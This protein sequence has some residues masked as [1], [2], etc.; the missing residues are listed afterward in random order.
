MTRCKIAYAIEKDSLRL[1]C[2]DEVPNGKACNCICPACGEKL[3]ARN[4]GSKL[5]HHFSHMSGNEC[6]YALQTTIHLL[7][8]EV[9]SEIK[10]IMLPGYKFF[11]PQLV[12]L[13][14]VEI[15]QRNDC[16]Y[17][18]PD[19]VGITER[20]V[21]ILIEIFVTHKVDD[22]KRKKI[23]EN[24]LNCIEIRFPRDTEP[25]K[26]NIAHILRTGVGLEAP[27][28]NKLED[29]QA[30]M[31]AYG[32]SAKRPF[33][34]SGYI[35]KHNE[36][37]DGPLGDRWWI[38][39]PCTDFA[40]EAENRKE[41]DSFIKWHPECS[42]VKYHDVL[43][44]CNYTRTNYVEDFYVIVEKYRDKVYDWV[45]PVFSMKPEWLCEHPIRI[46]NN[47]YDIN[48]KI[49]Y[50]NGKAHQINLALKDSSMGESTLA[51]FKELYANSDRLRHASSC[52]YCQD[53]LHCRKYITYDG[54]TYVFCDR[55]PSSND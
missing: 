38:N 14:D 53:C 28:K 33:D 23:I 49:V 26:D 9:L 43:G 25:T 1:V 37:L 44:K 16:K 46:Y 51:F 7:A 8:K 48:R 34:A 31:R 29:Y 5:S 50:I 30:T 20:G 35:R 39:N 3:V 10:E 36:I 21:R 42:F 45:K 41:I 4:G 19:L 2:V 22:N 11:G 13:K 32:W 17:I 6:E 40:L 47:R 27:W 24:N 12:K 54:D 18:Q 55:K 15:E 52:L